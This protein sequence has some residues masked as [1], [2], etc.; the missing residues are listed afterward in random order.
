MLPLEQ[1]ASSTTHA[2]NG[3]PSHTLTPWGYTAAEPHSA[4]SNASSNT[5]WM[6]IGA[7]LLSPPPL[8]SS[9]LMS[10]PVP[11]ATDKN[12]HN[13]LP[14]P[15]LEDNE[16]PPPRSEGQPREEDEDAQVELSPTVMDAA[17]PTGQ[18]DEDGAPTMGNG[19]WLV[20][21]VETLGIS[22][23]PPSDAAPASLLPPLLPEIRADDAAAS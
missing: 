21:L 13:Q 7:G 1:V 8:M 17:I 16:M 6:T 20:D 15:P 19:G 14:R 3:Q 12:I 10:P 22:L 4:Q 11:A 23:K 18:D 5:S 2:N 9:G